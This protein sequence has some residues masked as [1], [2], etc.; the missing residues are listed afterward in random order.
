MFKKILIANRGE[1]AT[2]ITRTC[3][4]MGIETVALYTLSDRDSLHVRLASEAVQL[5]SPLRYAAG[6]EIL[7]IAQRFGVD[8]IHPG[9]GFLAEEASFVEQCTAA[10]IVFIGPPPAVIR[11]VRNKMQAMEQVKAAGYAV[12]YFVDLPDRVTAAEEMAALAEQVGYP[13]IVKS[14]RGGRGVASG[15]TANCPTP[16][17]PTSRSGRRRR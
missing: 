15:P 2:R 5:Q 8:A 14:A 6:E 10:G 7:E 3:R 4:E 9:Y 1:I 16:P 17:M 13:L 11:A 12:P